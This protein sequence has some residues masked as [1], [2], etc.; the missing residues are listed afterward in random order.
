MGLIGFFRVEH[1]LNI[2][3][4]SEKGIQGNLKGDGTLL[5]GVF[6]IGPKD[7]GILYEHR[8]RVWGDHCNITHLL[9]AVSRINKQ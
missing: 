3:R 1:W 5:G 2:K 9:E 8:E 4:T 6:V 7:Q